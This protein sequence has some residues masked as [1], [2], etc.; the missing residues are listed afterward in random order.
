M[1]CG[2]SATGRIRPGELD[3]AFE[4]KRK[5][6]RRFIWRIE[7]RSIAEIIR[8]RK[9][10]HSKFPELSRRCSKQRCNMPF[11]LTDTKRIRNCATSSNQCSKT[12]RI[13]TPQ[14]QEINFGN[15]WPCLS[16]GAS[17]LALRFPIRPAI[18]LKY[19]EGGLPSGFSLISRVFRG[20]NKCDA[21]NTPGTVAPDCNRPRIFRPHVFWK[22]AGSLDSFSDQS[23]DRRR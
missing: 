23:T 5:P 10:A 15:A 16:F 14:R 17:A 20:L 18:A 11:P 4:G 9:I 22:F 13:S 21:T 19:S 3:A 12:R 8:A 2:G 7:N 6:N 1:E